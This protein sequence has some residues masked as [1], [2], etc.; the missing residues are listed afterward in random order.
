MKSIASYISIHLLTVLTICFITGIWCVTLLSP[1]ID[2][3]TLVTALVI[4]LLSLIGF[5]YLRQ[6]TYH[7]LLL[8]PL[9]TL[10]VGYLHG[11][12]HFQPPASKDHIYNLIL[13]STEAV[14]TGRLQEMVSYNGKMSKALIEL[15]SI[16]QKDNTFQRPAHGLVRLSFMGKWPREIIPGDHVIVRADIKRPHSFHTPGVF[17][18]ARFLAQKDIWIT[19]YIRSPLFVHELASDQAI[20]NKYKYL[21]EILRT[22][23]DGR[24]ES[25]GSVCLCHRNHE[26]E[27]RA[28]LDR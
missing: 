9:F 1:L 17:D 3:S 7:V 22:R 12:A 14:L 24:G 5:F 13:N 6:K 15:D 19:G 10:L 16:R 23:I 28:R 18:Y 21:P 8:L 27:K 25:H 4:L 26:R 20:T 11:L 2:I